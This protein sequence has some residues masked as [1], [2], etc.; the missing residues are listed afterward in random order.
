MFSPTRSTAPIPKVTNVAISSP[1]YLE[2]VALFET[3]IQS[4]ETEQDAAKVIQIFGD[5]GRRIYPHLF[6]EEGLPISILQL[7]IRCVDVV[8]PRYK[9][10]QYSQFVSLY[11][12]PIQTT[13]KKVDELRGMT[14]VSCVQY[15]HMM[16]SEGFY[17][18]IDDEMCVSVVEVEYIAT[19]LIP[20][21]R[22]KMEE[23]I[24]T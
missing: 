8:Y 9:H 18:F 14:L 1:Q 24:N 11:D 23:F 21:L 10:L 20:I 5:L 3:S 15:C 2:D 6:S 16:L 13:P 19:T 12:G 17:N 7:Y 22:E 4:L